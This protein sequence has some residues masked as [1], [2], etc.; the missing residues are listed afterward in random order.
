MIKECKVISYNKHLKILVFDFDGKQIQTS[1]DISIDTHTVYVK[2]INREYSLV[3]KKEFE[4]THKEKKNKSIKN[5]M[6]EKLVD[7]NL[8]G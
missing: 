7:C 2:F 3:S 4:N 5:I 8:E 6:E 1:V